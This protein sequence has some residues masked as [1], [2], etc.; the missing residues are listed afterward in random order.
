LA[1]ARRA[2]FAILRGCNFGIL[3]RA[4]IA[5]DRFRNVSARGRLG[6]IGIIVGEGSAQ[7]SAPCHL[8]AE[9]RQAV[10]RF[11]KRTSGAFSDVLRAQAQRMMARGFRR[12]LR[13]E[14]VHAGKAL[15]HVG[16]PARLD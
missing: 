1:P 4:L 11:L 14:L 16:T 9:K 15:A 12:L 8:V 3:W 10:G 5:S 2:G 6:S 7:S 13:G